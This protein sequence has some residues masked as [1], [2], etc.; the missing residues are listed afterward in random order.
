MDPNT[1]IHVKRCLIGPKSSSDDC[2]TN[3]CHEPASRDPL[4]ARLVSGSGENPMIDE[5]LPPWP[6][7]GALVH[8]GSRG[9]TNGVMAASDSRTP[10]GRSGHLTTIPRGAINI[11]W[12]GIPK[13]IGWVDGEKNSL[14]SMA[15][16]MTPTAS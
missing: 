11:T 6:S 4:V 13:R 12:P 9:V 14:A 3:V 7:L 16:W 15:R 1:V 8:P 2:Q 5:E 10:V